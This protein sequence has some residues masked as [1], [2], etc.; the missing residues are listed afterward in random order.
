MSKVMYRLAPLVLAIALSGCTIIP[1]RGDENVSL[2]DSFR[3]VSIASEAA[4]LSYE[5]WPGLYGDTVLNT[6]LLDAVDITDGKSLE[7]AKALAQLEQ[8]QAAV[9]GA[10]AS[11]WPT[12][13]LSAAGSKGRQHVS[14]QSVHTQSQSVSAIGRYE[15]DLWGRL[16]NQASAAELQSQSFAHALNAVRKRVTQQVVTQYWVLR[17]VDSELALLNSQIE[18]R[19]SQQTLAENRLK[20]GTGTELDVKQAQARVANAKRE[21]VGIETQRQQLEE[22][23]GL[24]VG[25]PD[26]RVAERA[27]HVVGSSLD[28]VS[29]AIPAQVMVQRS[30][31]QQAEYGLQAAGMNVAVARAA[32]FPSISFSAQVG[33]RNETLNTL[34]QPGNSFWTLG[35][36]LD[37][38]IFDRGLRLS[39]IDKAKAKQR[40]HM[41]DYQQAVQGALHDV[42]NALIEMEGL[43]RASAH[44]GQE[45]E[46]A[47]S[48]FEM[49]TYQYESGLIGYTSLLDAQQSHDAAQRAHVTLDFKQKIAEANYFHSLGF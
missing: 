31:V 10:K 11:L 39:Q 28:K 45:L 41:V 27:S 21:R 15:L 48:A 19:L 25:V 30:D 42:N 6:L 14:E 44:L 8:A 23:L 5:N 9:S 33:G 36:S 43:E 49:A 35:Y 22:T 46:A 20:Y 12:L 1:D 7:V 24:L 47:K 16:S 18:A 32:M 34:F 29:G 40:E 3:H 13:G 38:P 17:Q 37:L 4:A 26:L 2:P